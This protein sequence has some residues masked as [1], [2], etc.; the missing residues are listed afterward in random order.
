[1]QLG[2][3]SSYSIQLSPCKTRSFAF[4]IASIELCKSK[5]TTCL[6]K[7]IVFICYIFWYHPHL[8]TYIYSQPRLW[9]FIEEFFCM[10]SLNAD[11]PHSI[12][13]KI[14][15]LRDPFSI[16][17]L[18]ALHIL[19]L[20]VLSILWELSL[21]LSWRTLIKHQIVSILISTEASFVFRKMFTFTCFFVFLLLFGN[22]SFFCTE[23]TPRPSQWMSE[24]MDSTE[25][26]L[27]IPFLK[28]HTYLW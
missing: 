1:M 12:L 5:F 8:F 2:E 15:V 14:R 4:P 28:M 27:Y 25:F 17:L 16:L 13:Y 10:T 26:S 21:V 23:D 19:A 22:P 18:S 11:T 3:N 20:L 6:L 7:E 24:T 9:S